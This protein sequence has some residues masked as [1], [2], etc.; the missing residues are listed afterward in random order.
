MKVVLIDVNYDISST[1]KLLRNLQ[2]YGLKQGHE[3]HAFY[4]RGRKVREPNVH[5]FSFEL[6]TY[7]HA[8]LARITGLNGYF[9]IF[10]TLRLIHLLKKIKPDVIHIVEPHAYFVNT[11]LVINYIKANNIKSYMTIV[12]E[13][14]YTGKCG[15]A[16]DCINYQN[17]CNSCPQI[18]EY[19]RSLF[20]DFTRFMHNDKKK[21]FK[22]WDVHII[23]ASDWS[24]ERLKLSFLNSKPV[25]K[26][27]FGLDTS[28][29][30]P[31]NIDKSS[32]NLITKRYFV[33]VMGN[34]NDENKGFKWIEKIA[35]K[36]ELYNDV[37]FVVIGKNENIK[38]NLDNIE[39]I[40]SVTNQ[41]LLA[42]YYRN[43]IATIVV[44]QYETFSMVSQESI[45]CGTHV[46]G[47]NVGG[48]RDSLLG[49]DEYVVPYGSSELFTIV[50]RFITSSRNKIKPKSE[51]FDYSLMSKEYFR[52]YEQD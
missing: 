6:E 44:S 17:T 34:I 33:S 36:F 9:S 11:G 19:P 3:V 50:E 39:L 24:L 15:H 7:I 40:G 5:K 25:T 45:A 22:N 1:G 52:L 31:K 37:V 30:N 46:I 16:K 38:S 27:R 28:I 23:V 47:F 12:S 48:M 18:R 10:S 13:Y 41:A 49:Y 35:Q 42:E 8:L 2:K 51:S 14:M 32:H 29:F 20:F 4:G 26:I 43:A 21:W